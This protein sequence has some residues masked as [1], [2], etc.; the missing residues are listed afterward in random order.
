M[1][2]LRLMPL[3]IHCFATNDKF[4]AR[5]EAVDAVDRLLF[6]LRPTLLLQRHLHLL[7]R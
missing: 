3:I 5:R 1:G 4:Q 2:T 7:P 6:E